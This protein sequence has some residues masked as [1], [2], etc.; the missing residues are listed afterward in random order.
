MTDRTK[1]KLNENTQIAVHSI[2]EWT[3]ADPSLRD[4]IEQEV[5]NALAWTASDVEAQ[6]LQGGI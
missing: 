6:M 4:K 3:K 5:Y 2:M 1:A